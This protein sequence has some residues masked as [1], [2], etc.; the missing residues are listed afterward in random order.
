MLGNFSHPRQERLAWNKPIL[1]LNSETLWWVLSHE[2]FGVRS[3][4]FNMLRNYC[5]LFQDHV[6][7]D[8][9]LCVSEESLRVKDFIIFDLSWFLSLEL[10]STNLTQRSAAPSTIFILFITFDEISF[11]QRVGSTQQYHYCVINSESLTQRQPRSKSLALLRN[12][13]LHY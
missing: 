2:A 4:D 8:F 9:P 11:T 10:G 6:H 1:K 3:L 12:S 5:N 7:G 13:Q